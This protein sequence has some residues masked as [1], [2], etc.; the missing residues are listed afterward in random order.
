LKYGQ[1]GDGSTTN[2]IRPVIPMTINKNISFIASSYY[3]SMI[4][5]NGIAYSFGRNNY[6]QLGL[7]HLNNIL[8][9]TEILGNLTIKKIS[10]GTEHSVVLTTNGSVF[11]FGRNTV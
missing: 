1:L 2:S 9:P 11:C 8:V 10:L 4:I 6:G 5:Q 7:N 3:Y